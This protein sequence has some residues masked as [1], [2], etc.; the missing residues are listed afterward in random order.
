VQTIRQRRGSQGEDIAVAWLLEREWRVIAR[1]VKIGRRDEIDVIAIDP[2]PPTELVC[3][4][5]RS[6]RS[7]A[8]GAPEERLSGAKVGH[9]YRAAMALARSAEMRKLGAGRLPIRVD[10]LVVDLRNSNRAVRHLR[11]VESA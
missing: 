5:V 7:A 10:L 3:V 8:F 11:R 2:G 6:A 1:N 9:M 4:E